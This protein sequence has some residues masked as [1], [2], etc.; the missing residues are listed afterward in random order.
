MLILKPNC[1]CCDKDLPADSQDAM[2]C[3]FECTFCTA[4]MENFF[5]HQ[6]PNCGGEVSKRPTRD[7]KFLEKNPASTKRVLSHYDISIITG[8]KT[9]KRTVVS[10]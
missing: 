9:I 3:S 4:C 2:I 6:C 5:N 7:T 1:E 10:N 8:Q